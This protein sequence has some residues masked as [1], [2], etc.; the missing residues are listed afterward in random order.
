MRYV[1]WYFGS[2]TVDSW[3]NYIDYSYIVINY[4]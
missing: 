3:G 2:I 1:I 4:L